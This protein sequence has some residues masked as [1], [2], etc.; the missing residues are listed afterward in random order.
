MASTGAIRSKK[1]RDNGK[2]FEE[3]F[4]K[5]ARLNGLLVIKNYLTCRFV[6]AGQIQIIKGELDFKVANQ[7]GRV[8]YFDA[9]SYAADHFVFSALDEHQVKRSVV[10]NDYRIPSGFIVYFR[11]SNKIVFYDGKTIHSKGP[12]SR[13][14]ARDGLMLG[15]LEQFD[16]KTILA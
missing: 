14:E 8:G 5:Q 16:L 2:S 15:G 3:I 6:N 1:N 11:P 12:R 4:I 9:K 7:N 13:F 10:Y